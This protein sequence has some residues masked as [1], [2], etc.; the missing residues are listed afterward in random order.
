MHIPVAIIEMGLLDSLLAWIFPAGWI[1]SIVLESRS[2]EHVESRISVGEIDQDAV[3]LMVK[4]RVGEHM[5]KE[6]MCHP[7]VC[8]GYKNESHLLG[9]EGLVGCVVTV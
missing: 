7:G 2:R 4:A 6:F 9:F 5:K 8:I 1:N 3:G